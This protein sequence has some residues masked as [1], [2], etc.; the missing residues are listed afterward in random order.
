LRRRLIH[1]Q[2][3][4]PFYFQAHFAKT[5]SQEL[6][7]HFNNT[8]ENPNLTGI[9]DQRMNRKLSI[10]RPSSLT[11]QNRMPR[12]AYTNIFFDKDNRTTR[13]RHTT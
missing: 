11:D 4:K 13:T 3:R 2:G 5:A 1:C 10:K 12:T 9:I 8:K 6:E 7:D